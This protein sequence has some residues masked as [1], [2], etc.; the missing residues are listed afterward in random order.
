MVAFA[1]KRGI[2]A[3][4]AATILTTL[5]MLT[6]VGP[7]VPYPRINI[8]GKTSDEHKKKPSWGTAV[9]NPKPAS[10]HSSSTQPSSATQPNPSEEKLAIVTFL[11]GTLDKEDNWEDDEYFSATRLLAWQLLH[12]PATKIRR[13]NLDF[14]VIVTPSVSKSRRERLE[15]DGAKLWPVEFLYAEWLRGTDHEMRWDDLMGKL[16]VWEMV[17]YSRVL[18]LDGDIILREP[19]DGIFDDPGTKFQV[20]NRSSAVKFPLPK[21]EELPELP[22]QYMLGGTHE[23]IG[24]VHEF[25]PTFENNGLQKYGYFNAGFFLLA[26]NLQLFDYYCRLMNT[27][28]GFD[29][30]YM[31]QN[32][33]NRI[34]AWD[35]ALP[36]KLIDVKWNMVAVN[37]A[38]LDGG[39]KSM[40]QKWFVEP[41]SHSQRVRDISMKARWEMQGWYDAM[42][43]ARELEEKSRA[44]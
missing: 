33:L 1:Q 10:S 38:D 6:L 29:P 25:P 34:H 22:D 23:T 30:R 17:E 36:W 39:V 14:Y 44:S 16:R 35:G 19:L 13:Q 7:S 27:K 20:T 4:V 21:G 3:A 43:Q 12:S 18:L 41:T 11:S 40:H 8:G 5:L 31:E 32:L 9:H 37:D 24:P 42:D 2:I 26:P 28:D 15:K